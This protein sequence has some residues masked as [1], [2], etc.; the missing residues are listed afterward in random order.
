MTIALNRQKAGFMLAAFD[1]AR[2]F[3]PLVM[4]ADTWRGA[5]RTERASGAATLRDDHG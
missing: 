2:L 1:P 5:R 4:R 3:P